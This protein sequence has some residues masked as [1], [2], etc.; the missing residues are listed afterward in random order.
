MND[1]LELASAPSER[2]GRID[3]RRSRPGAAVQVSHAAVAEE[4]PSSD[5]MRCAVEALL[6]KLERSVAIIDR[7]ARLLFANAPARSLLDAGM[8]IMRIGE[9]RLALATIDAQRRLNAYLAGNR[10]QFTQAMTVRVGGNGCRRPCRV[11]ATPLSS[12]D[13]DRNHRASGR[14]HAVCV[15]EIETPLTVSPQI[16][17]QVYG[18]TAAEAQA[19]VLLFAGCSVREIA[20]RACVSV[21][22]VRTH[23]KHIF[24][25]CGVASQTQLMRLLALGPKTL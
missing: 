21:S 8:P 7:Q 23:L 12:E 16:L 4:P 10:S 19:T 18:L 2:G 20:S 17:K 11:V 6:D 25:K 22:T 15:Y 5:L 3:R 13:L 9:E 24:A 1:E 14:L